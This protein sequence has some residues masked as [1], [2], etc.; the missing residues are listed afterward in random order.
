MLVNLTPHILNVQA[1]DGS[2]IEL[3]PSGQVARVAVKR[4]RSVNVY[5][6]D[7]A[8]TVYESSFG[9]VEGLPEDVGHNHYVVSRMVLDALRK[10]GASTY[11]MYAPGELVRDE[12]GQP[13]GCLGL[14]Y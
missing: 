4:L 1:A 7:T 12:K 2:W 11:A 13:I 3:P 9:A 14:S 5:H 8:V 10:A 6:G